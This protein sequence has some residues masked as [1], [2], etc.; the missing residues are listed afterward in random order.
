[1]ETLKTE[2]PAY[3]ISLSYEE[4]YAKGPFFEGPIPK[5]VI[6]QRKRFLDF[7]VNSLIGIPAGPLLNANWIRVYAALGFDLPIYKTVRTKAHPSHPPPNCLYVDVQGQ[8]TEERFGERLQKVKGEWQRPQEEISITNSFGMP[9][10]DP[11]IWQEDVE[12]AKSWLE[13]G[14]LLTVSV[15]GTMGEGNLIADYARGA[16]MAKEAGA[17]MVEIN[18]SCPNV[19][20]G[21]G[22]LFTDPDYS[23]RLCREVKGVLRE[24]PLIIKIGYLSD[25]KI[26]HE[27]VRATASSVQV[28]SG[29][30]TLSFEVVGEDGMPALPGQGRLH[31][32]ICG[33]SIRNCAMAQAS[34]LA[35]LRQRERYDFAIIGVGGIM[36]VADIERY[37]EIGVDAV[38]SATGAM[39]DPYLAYRYWQSHYQEG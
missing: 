13:Q 27:M 15:V 7:E 23:G 22:E 2:K 17:D 11:R 32:G 14:Q 30:N 25:Q 21:E 36:T 8:L 5:R 10:R 4:N 16:A 18:L 9:S 37:F 24:T 38:M 39:W 20:S 29:I 26:L 31:S 35:H 33:A 34:R 6:Q 28:I 19:T 1:M 12:G 3:D